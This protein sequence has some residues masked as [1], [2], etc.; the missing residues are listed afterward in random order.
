M[1]NDPELVIGVKHHC[2]RLFEG[3]GNLV[4]LSIEVDSLVEI[5][6]ARV[7]QGEV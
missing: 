4:V 7:P 5:D 2:G 6:S 1:L 3:W